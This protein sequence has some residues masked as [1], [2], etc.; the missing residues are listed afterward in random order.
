MDRC[1]LLR[2]VCRAWRDAIDSAPNLT[3]FIVLN[4][5]RNNVLYV[6]QYNHD[7]LLECFFKPG[8]RSM[9]DKL[10]S[11]LG[12]LTE[13][14]HALNID[15]TDTIIEPAAFPILQALRIFSQSNSLE[16][17]GVD[18][19]RMVRANPGLRVLVID[20][21]DNPFGKARDKKPTPP[22]LQVQHSCLRVV[23]LTGYWSSYKSDILRSLGLDR[24]VQLIIDAV[25]PACL[26]DP[27]SAL[28]KMIRSLGKKE[29]TGIIRGQ[30]DIMVKCL[31]FHVVRLVW[32]E[33]GRFLPGETFSLL[34]SRQ[35][36]SSKALDM[37][38]ELIE[39]GIVE[40]VRFCRDRGVGYGE[41]GCL[42]EREPLRELLLRLDS[43]KQLNLDVAFVGLILPVLVEYQDNQFL[44]PNLSQ[45]ECFGEE[46]KG[47]W[48]GGIKRKDSLVNIPSRISQLIKKRQ[49]S[50][51]SGNEPAKLRRIGVPPEL[52]KGKHFKDPIFDGIEVYPAYKDLNSGMLTP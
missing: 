7:S 49:R 47:T 18:P 37:I 48:W 6:Q 34:I 51:P 19:L 28:K 43:V 1:A 21:P 11:L 25:Q 39:S 14:L 32:S 50:T 46:L 36:S 4:E 31:G 38:R 13:R 17:W 35:T 20:F 45:L 3:R 42:S 24:S 8:D 27:E 22:A 2:T 30:L 52:M 44:C 26:E 41:A 16:S 23:Q 5:R 12:P 40:T 9:R 15:M 33:T 29:Q 10:P